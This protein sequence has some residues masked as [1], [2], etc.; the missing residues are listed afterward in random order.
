MCQAAC[1]AEG[2]CAA[3]PQRMLARTCAWVLRVVVAAAVVDLAEEALDAAALRA[4][5]S[6]CAHSASGATQAYS[7]CWRLTR[8]RKRR[9]RVAQPN[10]AACS[11]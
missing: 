5:V 9:M 1:T 11:T 3:A 10:D 2:A 4:A 6:A 7:S 8:E